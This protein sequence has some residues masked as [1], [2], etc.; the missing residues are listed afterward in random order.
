MITQWASSASTSSD[1]GVQ[2]LASF[3]AQ[4]APR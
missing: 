2:A 4:K 1:S 3:I